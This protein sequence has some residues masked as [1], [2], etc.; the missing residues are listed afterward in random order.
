MIKYFSLQNFDNRSLVSKGS[1]SNF[2][3]PD[4]VVSLE[5]NQ[6]KLLE[7]PKHCQGIG[8]VYNTHF[9]TTIQITLFCT[10]YAT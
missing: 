9:S 2:A 3:V 7:N 10:G 6:K 5:D 8:N 1:R 4:T